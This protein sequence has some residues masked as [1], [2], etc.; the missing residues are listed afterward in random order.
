MKTDY[1]WQFIKQITFL[2]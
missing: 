1:Y 2:L